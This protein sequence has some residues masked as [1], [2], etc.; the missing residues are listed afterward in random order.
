MPEQPNVIELNV[1]LAKRLGLVIEHEGT[2]CICRQ[3]TGAPYDRG[4]PYNWDPCMSMDDAMRAWE[5]C[6]CE[7]GSH[8]AKDGIRDG[9]WAAVFIRAGEAGMDGAKRPA[10]ALSRALYA[11]LTMRRRGDER[12]T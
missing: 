3:P 10:E 4:V 6:G 7:S 11:W 1:Y 2:P 8:C 9:E 12:D 5:E